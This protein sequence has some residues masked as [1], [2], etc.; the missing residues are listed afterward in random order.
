M[1]LI[2]CK[3]HHFG[4]YPVLLFNY[5]NLGLS[6]IYGP[7]G[8]GKS[9]IF[10]IASWCLFGETAKNG[11]ADDVRSWSRLDS[12][13]KVSLSLE[14][15]NDIIV[16]IRIRG[17]GQNDLYWHKQNEIAQRGKDLTDSQ[18]KLN[19]LLGFDSHTYF[20][21]AYFSEFSSTSSFFVD[22]AKDRRDLFEKLADLTLPKKV[23]EY[24]T[25]NKKEAST[26]LANN[27]KELAKVE[28]RIEQLVYAHEQALLNQ[29]KWKASRIKH[30]D[31]LTKQ[32]SGFDQDKQNKLLNL[33]DKSIS[34]EK[35]KS[36]R[37]KTLVMAIS[38]LRS[39]IKSETYYD[40]QIISTQANH[41]DVCTTCYRPIED[42]QHQSKIR[43]LR[44]KKEANQKLI[45]DLQ[46]KQQRLDMISLETNRYLD[47]I[48]D[49]NK[50][51]NPYGAQVEKE[52]L[53]KDPFEAQIQDIHT[54]L[55]QQSKGFELTSKYAG[56][57]ETKISHL[58]ILQ[59]LMPTLR[60]AL[61]KQV[62][63]SIQDETNR[64]LE[65]YFDA[66]IRVVFSTNDADNIE[67]EI[68][69]SGHNCNFKQLSKG[70][71][72]LLKLTFAAAVMCA[73]ANHVGT[74]FSNVFMD[75]ALD[76]L[77]DSL[78]IKSFKLL[79]ELSNHHES[80]IIIDHSEALQNLFDRKFKVTI[81]ENCSRITEEQ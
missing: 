12:P 14:I 55:A 76:G 74:H 34:F 56:L 57:L 22:K 38:D 71:R 62:I 44:S 75:E 37:I 16:V 63:T 4:S 78:K 28:G 11:S 9:T 8:S 18:K 59:D 66:E 48:E 52:I 17:K 47:Q 73:S 26:A 21:A 46:F 32:F 77:D 42:E 58:S 45:Y 81:E 54:K 67:V 1:K 23:L 72:G 6:L 30:I 19:D 49:L 60:G 15:N 35:S 69:K 79:Q 24:C 29:Q 33:K 7:T 43:D 51:T 53:S 2:E 61:L 20:T 80:V 10:D 5:D 68:Q 40:N 27:N 3:A 13:T 36:D 50:Q 31:D 39:S 41:D 65:T 25:H 70:Q 64:Y